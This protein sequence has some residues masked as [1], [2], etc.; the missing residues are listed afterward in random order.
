[1][2]QAIARIDY[3]KVT[4]DMRNASKAIQFGLCYGLSKFGLAK[5]LKITEKKAEE[6]IVKYFTAYSGV[7]KFLDKS[8]Q[9]AVL[10]GYSLSISGRKRFYRLPSLD[11][12]ER[13]KQQRSVERKGKNAPI[14]GANADTIKESMIILCDKLEKG[15]YDAKLLLTVHDELIIEAKN[16]QKYE[17]SKIVERSLIAGFGKYFHKIPM[18][19]DSLIGPC[20][21]KGEC[22]DKKGGCG[23]AEFVAQEDKKYGTKVVCAKCGKENI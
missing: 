12:P 19:T 22:D 9:K 4:P 18:E 13:Q 8:G 1:M 16:E 7:K 2:T 21:L 15:G 5:R 14:Q 23:H 11:H 6:M 17:V 20:W 10:N 3:D